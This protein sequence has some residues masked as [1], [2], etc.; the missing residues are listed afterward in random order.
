LGFTVASIALAIGL[1]ITGE[2]EVEIATASLLALVPAFIGVFVG[3]FLRKKIPQEQFRRY[4]FFSLLL[5]GAATAF[6]AISLIPG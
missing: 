1:L 4:F 5:L 3:Q 6:R 2:Y